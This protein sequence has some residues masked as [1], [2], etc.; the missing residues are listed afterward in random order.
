MAPTSIKQAL[1]PLA[2]FRAVDV[3]IQPMCN[4]YARNSRAM[5]IIAAI[6]NGLW[7]VVGMGPS[8]VEIRVDF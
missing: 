1:K 7:M 5:L 4:P 3:L 2:G 6:I 8:V